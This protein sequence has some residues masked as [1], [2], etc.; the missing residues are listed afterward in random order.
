MITAL[1]SSTEFGLI[2]PSW[3]GRPPNMSIDRYNLFL[4]NRTKKTYVETD[5]CRGF[6]VVLKRAVMEKI[7][8]IDEIYGLAYFDDVDYSVTAIEAGF[9]CLLSLDTFVYHH[10]NVTFFEILKGPKWN[11]LHEKN[12]HIYYHKW[13]R[14]LKVFIRIPGDVLKNEGQRERIEEMVYYLARKQHRVYLWCS[15]SRLK[16]SIFHTNIVVRAF[17]C[18]SSDVLAEMDLFFNARKKEAKRYNAVFVGDERMAASFSK[19]YQALRVFGWKAGDPVDTFIK[20]TVDRLKEK[21]KEN[22]NAWTVV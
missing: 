20:H 3:E 8:T 22:E 14:P 12:K 4:E 16:N 11:E 13:G 15:D 7:G 2:N 6:S 1:G 5:W 21:T 18:C 10:R 19:R 17:P 9:R